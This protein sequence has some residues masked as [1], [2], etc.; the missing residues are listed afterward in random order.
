MH[1]TRENGEK[2]PELTNGDYDVSKLTITEQKTEMENVPIN[3]DV[4]EPTPTMEEAEAESGDQFIEISVTEPQKVGEGM[5]AYMAYRVNTRTNKPLFKK[6]EF[7]VIRRFSDFLGLHDKLTE[8]YLKVGRIIPPAPE[9]SVIGK[10]LAMMWRKTCTLVMKSVVFL[11]VSTIFKRF[12]I[13]PAGMTKI[14]MSNQ[15]DSSGSNGNEF[16]ERR[17]AALERYLQRTAEHPVLVLDPD[18][19]EFLESGM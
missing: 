11:D 16:I 3:N 10:W 8:K 7:S 5:G 12:G 9:K 2:Q 18:F 6:R 1:V 14:K 17:R 13:N 4:S 19:R 15:Q